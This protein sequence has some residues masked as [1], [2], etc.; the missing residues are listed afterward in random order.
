[1]TITDD[2][3][4]PLLS[5][6][7]VSVAEANTTATFAGHTERRQREAGDLEAHHGIGHGDRRPVLATNADYVALALLSGF[8]APGSVSRNFSVSICTDSADEPNETVPVVLSEIVNA[9]APDP[10]ATL[11][12]LDD[13][14]QET[15]G[16]GPS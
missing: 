10:N 5:I 16:G 4:P 9:T 2:D 6:A 13:D 14:D 3:A 11:T 15:G 7:D 1:M 12:I 8:N